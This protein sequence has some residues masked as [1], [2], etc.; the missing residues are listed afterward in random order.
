[1]SGVYNYD[2]Q[3][4]NDPFVEAA[5]V[6]LRRLMESVFPGALAVNMFPFLAKLPGWLPGMGFQKFCAGAYTESDSINR[7]CAIL[8]SRYSGAGSPDEK[9]AV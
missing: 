1:M 7:T 9:R 5:E 4:S 6:A 2:I 3:P 8:N